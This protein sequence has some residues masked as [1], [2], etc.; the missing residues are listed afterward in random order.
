MLLDF[1][2]AVMSEGITDLSWNTAYGTLIFRNNGFLIHE[3][4]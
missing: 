3:L 4:T 2:M 1:C